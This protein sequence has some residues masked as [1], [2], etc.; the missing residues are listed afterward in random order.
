MLI[1]NCKCCGA[2]MVWEHPKIPTKYMVS[3]C[4]L[5]G[6]EICHDCMVEHCA[7]TNCLNCEYGQ[8]PGCR[9]LELKRHYLSSDSEETP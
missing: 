5:E 9:F 2:Q 7:Q 1:Q 8:Y 4:N 6:W 3:S